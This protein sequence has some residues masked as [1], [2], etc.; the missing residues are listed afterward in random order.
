MD[1]GAC[2]ATVD[3]VAELDMAEATKHT[4]AGHKGWG[5]GGRLLSSCIIQTSYLISLG[6]NFLNCFIYLFFIFICLFV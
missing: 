2:Q 1:R 3:R 5:S 4:Y 6:L